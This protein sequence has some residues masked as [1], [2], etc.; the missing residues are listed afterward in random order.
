MKLPASVKPYLDQVA[1][2]AL[3]S[4][5]QLQE[6][7]A[8][9]QRTAAI[10]SGRLGL[11]LSEL[12]AAHHEVTESV[13]GGNHAV[14]AASDEEARVER[15]RALSDHQRAENLIDN[16]MQRSRFLQERLQ[17]FTQQLPQLRRAITELQHD[18]AALKSAT[19]G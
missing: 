8:A 18:Q 10:V 13:I 3:L 5:A 15:A 12:N 17:S 11:E 14:N 4:L 9:L 16:A 7:I 19:D 6:S 1:D 2:D